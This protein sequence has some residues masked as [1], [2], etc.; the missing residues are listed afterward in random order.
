MCCFSCALRSLWY[1]RNQSKARNNLAL[2][3]KRNAVPYTRR[4]EV[5]RPHECTVARRRDDDVI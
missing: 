2:T 5:C 3:S 4:L 1:S